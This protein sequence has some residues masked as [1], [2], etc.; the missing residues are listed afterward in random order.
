ML[1]ILLSGKPPFDG[2]NDNDITEKV[3]K[4]VYYMSGKLWDSISE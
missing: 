2:K 4:G 1:Y 3:K